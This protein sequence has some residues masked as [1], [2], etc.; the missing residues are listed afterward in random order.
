MKLSLILCESEEKLTIYSEIFD[1]LEEILHKNI[2]DIIKE[3]I[4]ANRFQHK[5]K[6]LFKVTFVDSS[7]VYH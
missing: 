7:N 6:F 2:D 1:E 5:L 3:V 4:G